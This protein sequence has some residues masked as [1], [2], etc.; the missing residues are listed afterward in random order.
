MLA[1]LSNQVQGTRGPIVCLARRFYDRNHISCRCRFFQRVKLFGL[2]RCCASFFCAS[3][4][5][6]SAPEQCQ[7]MTLRVGGWSGGGREEG[8]E[9]KEMSGVVPCL[10]AYA[11]VLSK[12]CPRVSAKRP[13]VSNTRGPFSTSTQTHPKHAAHANT[14]PEHT[15]AARTTIVKHQRLRLTSCQNERV[16]TMTYHFHATCVWYGVWWYVFFLSFA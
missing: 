16:K 3:L 12:R 4:F 8:R 13:R 10:S 9:E 6:A 11:W 15:H 2:G 7:A 1:S 14:R 5:C